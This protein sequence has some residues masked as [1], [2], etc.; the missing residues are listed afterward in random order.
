MSR[1]D[2]LTMLG[3]GL[4]AAAC[5]SAASGGDASDGGGGGLGGAGSSGTGGATAT[6]GAGSGSGGTV[7]ASCDTSAGGWATAGTSCMTDVAEYPNPFGSLGSVC[8]AQPEPTIGPCHTT[9]PLRVDVTNGLEGIPL[10]IALRVVDADCQPIEGALVEIWHTDFQGGYSGDIVDM[11]TR[12]EAD[13][14][15]DFM[16]GYQPTDADGVAYFN[17]CFPGWYQGRAVH[18]HVRILTTDYAAADN[19]PAACITQLLWADDFVD[20]IFTSVPLYAQFGLPDTHLSNDN[21]VGGA[22]DQS[23]FVFDVQQTSDGAM[24]CSKTI[25]IG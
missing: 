3:F 17:S 14:Q 10:R 22:S 12:E 16:R 6:G 11:C 4:A 20:E 21:V 8:P 23:M 25:S 9:S 13:K 7:A 1:R 24:L 19:A 2:S 18:V 15:E 5:G